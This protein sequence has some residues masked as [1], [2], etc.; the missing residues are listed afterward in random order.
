[1]W[2][3]N[4]GFSEIYGYAAGTLLGRLG[5][6][7]ARAIGL[8][9]EIAPDHRRRARWAGAGALVA[10]TAY[11]WVR[12]VLRQREISQLVQQEPKNLATHLVGTAAGL[13]ASAGALVVARAVIATARLYRLLLRP[14]LPARL[15]GTA[16]LLLTAATVAVLLERLVRG[17]MLE[18]TIERA[19]VTNALISPSW[20]HPPRRCARAARAPPRPGSPS[21]PRAARS[22]PA[23]RTATGSRRPSDRRRSTRSGSTPPPPPSAPW[24][25]PWTR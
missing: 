13:G 24:S 20:P 4:I 5:R 2:T 3:A 22:S 14:Y 7:A 12:G 9:V 16:S 21:A 10:I 11:S 18:R 19:E 6:G 8:Q 25:G 1:M 15:L 23:A 17:G